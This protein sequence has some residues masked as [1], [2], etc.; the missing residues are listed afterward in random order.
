MN[1]LVIDEHRI[2]PEI[3]VAQDY[4]RPKGKAHIIAIEEMPENYDH[5]GIERII[6]N[7]LFYTLR[8]SINRHSYSQVFH[9]PYP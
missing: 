2:L 4:K 9:S 6:T 7:I 5:P 8:F 1:A 3:A